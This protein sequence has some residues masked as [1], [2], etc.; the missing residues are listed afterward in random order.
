MM[1]LAVTGLSMKNG[2]IWCIN[3]SFK[4][5]G[6]LNCIHSKRTHGHSQL[7]KICMTRLHFSGYGT[8]DS[9]GQEVND[10]RLVSIS[11]SCIWTLRLSLGRYCFYGM[12]KR[13]KP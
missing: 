5:I 4:R 8:K 7:G 6:K 9:L 13:F 2:C 12:A 3:E 11:K 10:E 1:V